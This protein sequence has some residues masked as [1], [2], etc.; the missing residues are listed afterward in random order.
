VFKSIFSYFIAHLIFSIQPLKCQ[1]SAAARALFNI[2]A[3]SRTVFSLSDR[4]DVHLMEQLCP[5][6]PLK[7]TEIENA[8]YFK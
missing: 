8:L 2:N 7:V 1:V 3:H 4:K 6:H 5:V